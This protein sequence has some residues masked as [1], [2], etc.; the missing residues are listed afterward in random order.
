KVV[1]R[2]I[3]NDLKKF[4]GESRDAQTIT[5]T[6]AD[7][8]KQW[9]FGR[10]L[11]PATIHKRLQVVRSFFHVLKRRKVIDTNPFADVKAAATGI[12]DRQRFVKREEIELVLAACPDHHW[13]LIVALARYGGLRTPSETLSLRW[14]DINWESSRIIVQSPKT[15][16][17]GKATRIMPLFT[18]LRPYLER[19]WD[20]ASEGAVYVVDERFRRGALRAGNWANSNL[21]T[22]FEKIVTRAGV[23]PWPRLFHNLRASRET[24]LVQEHPVQVVTSWLGNSPAIAL[25]HY[26]MVRD[27]DFERALERRPE[28]TAQKTTQQAH[29]KDGFARNASHV[30]NGPDSGTEKNPREKQGFAS[31]CDALPSRARLISESQSNPARI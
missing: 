20:L 11:A 22:T 5:E 10:K 8:F 3:V 29:V 27:A 13:R 30:E 31:R 28:K 21:R 18:E 4:F 17:H 26:L 1:C 25:K 12:S 24:E 9:L 2:P 16:C 23:E 7:E 19:S 15:A 6:E 14:Q